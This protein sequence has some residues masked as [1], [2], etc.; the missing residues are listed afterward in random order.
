MAAGSVLLAVTWLYWPTFISFSQ[1]WDTDP[2][3][4]HGPLIPLVAIGIIC[5]RGFPTEIA[6]R[7]TWWG[8]PVLVVGLTLKLTSQHFYFEWLES[9]SL[10]PVTAGACLM[11]TGFSLFRLLWPAIAFLI[12]MMPLPYRIE[13][14]IVHPLQNMATTVSTFA[15][16]TLGYAARH[17][18][19]VVWIGATPVGIAEAC[20]GL[21]MLTGFVALAVAA[22]L[23]TEKE[24]WK[25]GC[26]LASAV[27]V[28]LI[29]NV[30]RVT[31]MGIAHSTTTDA[32]FHAVL[33]DVLGWLMPLGAVGLLW[34]ELWILDRLL[35]AEETDSA[36]KSQPTDL[37][38]VPSERRG[39]LAAT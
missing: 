8:I 32:E 7:P 34:L 12:F 18:G 4:S 24:S 17:E 26:L 14:E 22:V 27:P 37:D 6:L 11:L 1:R 15:L 38:S 21:R 5:L 35:V 13:V 39:S 10:I 33:H 25:R 19:N 23:V 20:S 2:Q 9:I 29:C 30:V 16:Q 31:L 28:A 36:T 3:Y